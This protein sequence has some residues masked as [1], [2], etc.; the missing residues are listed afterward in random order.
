MLVKGRR[1]DIP[2][3]ADIY[4]MLF[5]C[6]NLHGDRRPPV[7]LPSLHFD[8]LSWRHSSN[9]RLF[10]VLISGSSENCIERLI[11]VWIINYIYHNM[12]GKITY[13][14]PNFNVC[15]VEFWIWISNLLPHFIGHVITDAM[16]VKGPQVIVQ[17]HSASSPNP[18]PTC[19]LSP[20]PQ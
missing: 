9:G 4:H 2:N 18:D 8:T 16:L 7:I 3:D 15:T 14:L 11:P 6:V 20:I 10:V 1:K 17:F 5:V 13:Q 19:A 12:W